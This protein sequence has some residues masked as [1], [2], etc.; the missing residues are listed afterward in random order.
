MS[1]Y[2]PRLVAPTCLYLASK[3]EE[4]TV[5]ARLLVFY[6]KKMCGMSYYRICGH[7]IF[8]W[9]NCTKQLFL[10]LSKVQV[11][12]ISIGLK[13]RIFLKWKWSSWKHLTIIWLFFIH[14]VLSYSKLTFPMSLLVFS[15]NMPSPYVPSFQFFVLVE[16]HVDGFP[17]LQVIAGCWHNRSDAICLVSTAFMEDMIQVQ[18]LRNKCWGKLYIWH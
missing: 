4:S 10:S 3:V 14:T 6:I 8:S 9:K 2:D 15:C 18:Q 1:E 13:L 12:M 7:N 16:F 5:Q 17:F 11:P